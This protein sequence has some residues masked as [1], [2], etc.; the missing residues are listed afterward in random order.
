MWRPLSHAST[1]VTR[2]VAI[3]DQVEVATRARV[4]ALLAQSLMDTDQSTRRTAAALEALEL[5]RS[6]LDPR[7]L[8][9]VAPDILHAL[10]EPG[11]GPTRSALAAEVVAIT[12]DLGD[13]HLMFV[14]NF[15]AF[16]ASVCAGDAMS[17]ARNL[18]RIHQ[19]VG[20]VPEPQMRW[21]VGTLDAFVATMEASF[22][23]AEVIISETF[24]L[25]L[26]IGEPEALAMFAAQSFALG[27]FTGR[28]AELLPFIEAGLESEASVELPFLIGHAIVCCETGR[29][30]VASGLLRDAIEAGLDA[31][32]NDFMRTTSLLGYAVLA[33][34]L[35]D[36]EAAQWLYPEVVPLAGEV[37]FN[38]ITGQG[39][40]SGYAGKLAS[41][42]GEFEDAERLLLAALEVTESFGWVYHRAST[43]I[44]L[45]DNRLRC[46][47]GLTDDGEEWL[48]TAEALCAN[49][50]I[51]F[52]ARRAEALRAR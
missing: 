5:A 29:T 25:G 51:G 36:M 22:A 7:L 47:G 26:E 44:A 33:L 13:P 50:E 45:A 14:A 1:T 32:P 48:A 43:L 12:D 16:N 35:Q 34:E 24:E 23:D 3:L 40:I 6:S 19:V 18:E 17:A 10:W 31:I 20:E 21:S 46:F 9:E 4:T 42:L 41:L 38:G 49:H 52:W 28:H 37:S 15:A 30:E 27:T 11:A 39:P 2:I 8:A